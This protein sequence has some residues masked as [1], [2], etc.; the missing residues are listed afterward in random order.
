MPWAVAAAAVISAGTTIYSVSQNR[1][2][3]KEAI[4][5]EE[6]G[7][8]PTDGLERIRTVYQEYRSRSI[9]PLAFPFLFKV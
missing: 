6:R 2:T 7:P 8:L 1:K 9:T 5:A 3:A 4:A